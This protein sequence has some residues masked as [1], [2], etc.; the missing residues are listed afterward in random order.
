VSP[1]YRKRKKHIPHGLKDV[2]QRE[3][4][5]ELD[6]GLQKADWG[7]EITPEMLE[8]AAKD[9]QVLLPLADALQAKVQEDTLD[10]ILALERRVTPAMVW[11]AAT[12]VPIDEGGWEAYRE[13]N[14]TEV[15]KAME[16]LNDIAPDRPGGELWNWNSW[17]QIVRVFELLGHWLADTTKETLSECDHPLAG[18]LLAYRNAKKRLD[19]CHQ[20][21]SQA[22]EGRVYA[23]WRQVGAET[24]RMSCS[25]PNLQ[26]LHK[27]DEMRRF[28]QAPEGRVLIKADY[29]QMEL[30]ILAQLSG[31]PA[32][33]GAFEMGEDLHKATATKMYSI[34]KEEV[35]PEQRSSAKAISFGIV[36]GMTPIVSLPGSGSSRRCC[37][38]HRAVLRRLPEGQGIP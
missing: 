9:F 16:R 19:T 20:W 10:Q 34:P 37:G 28:V 29:S 25:E 31:D 5:I 33:I 14:K 8:Y 23:S 6:K 1:R 30:R 35:T 4:G 11:M 3:L 2:V 22:R 7:G 12:G 15:A 38:A 17:Q 13:K 24:G 26:N 21:L 32:M 36:Y 18:A 27:E